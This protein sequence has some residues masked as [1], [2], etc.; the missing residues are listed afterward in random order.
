MH[1]SGQHMRLLQ[2][3]AGARHAPRMAYAKVNNVVGGSDA[4][5]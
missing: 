4:I 1:F 3:P 2:G 5:G